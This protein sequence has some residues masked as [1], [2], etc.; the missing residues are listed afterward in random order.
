M[1]AQN[2]GGNK[3]TQQN[4]LLGW[5]SVGKRQ[6]SPKILHCSDIASNLKEERPGDES[7]MRDFKQ[8][9]EKPK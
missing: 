9:P 8:E 1:W 4:P 3:D 5:N 2:M 6:I 7:Q